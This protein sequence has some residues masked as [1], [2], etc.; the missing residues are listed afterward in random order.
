MVLPSGDMYMSKNLSNSNPIKLSSLNNESY[1]RIK[2]MILCGDLPWGARIEV[3]QLAESFGIS[4]FPVIK[5]IERLSLEKLV[6]V[7]P[8]KGTFVVSPTDHDVREITEIRKILEPAACRLAYEKNR[9]RLLDDIRN[10]QAEITTFSGNTQ[11]T[12]PFRDFL[13]YDRA[14]HMTLFINAGNER[15]HAYY[16]TVRSQAELFRTKTFILRNIDEALQKHQQI[17]LALSQGKLEEAVEQLIEHLSEVHHD[18][19]ISLA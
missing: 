6:V 11:G 1:L 5:A 4:K 17:F 2:D 13:N 15:L 7:S 10:V 9:S 8:N 16:K 18:T 3:G 19:I 12:I 14:F